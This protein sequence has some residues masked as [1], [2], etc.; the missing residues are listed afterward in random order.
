MKYFYYLRSA[1]VVFLLCW[2]FFCLATVY[3]IG[4][5]SSFALATNELY[6]IKSEI[7][8][9]IEGQKLA[10][11][12][13]SSSQLGISCELISE[14][15]QLSCFN[16]GSVLPLGTDYL[17]K[18]AR[19][20]LKPGD[21]VVL[22]LEYSLYQDD[23]QPRQELIEYILNYDHQYFFSADLVTKMRL[24][25]GLSLAALMDRVTAK[26]QHQIPTEQSSELVAIRNSINRYGDKVD[27]QQEKMSPILLETVENLTPLKLIG[28]Q[29][30]T[31]GM[32]SIQRFTNWCN[33]NEIK[34]IASWPNT[35]WFEEYG[36][37]P[38]QKFLQ[39]IKD[40]YR[41]QDIPILG[42]PEDFMYDKSMFYD[43]IYH[44]HDKGVKLR[45]KQLMAKLRPYVVGLF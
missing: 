7:A 4:A 36:N 28:Y 33:Q 11:I 1:A 3:S 15:I 8:E 32:Q 43:S 40:F 41:Q 24:F 22:P 26:A 44:L 42:E 2:L 30:S 5:P 29:K 37:P 13:G 34:V 45:T 20:W 10:I 25:G 38:Q 18:R 17:L 14:T 9:K 21:T 27:N 19:P 6:D 23:G 16:G 31:H 12:S 35:V 39:S